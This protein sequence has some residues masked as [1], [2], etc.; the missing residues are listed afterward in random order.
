MRT[1]AQKPK[2]P[3]QA[4]PVKSTVPSRAH[5]RQSHEVNSILHLQRTIGNQAVQR[6]LQANAEEL[7]AGLTGT[8]PPRSWSDFS[9][10]PIY[11]PAAGAIQTKLAINKPG[12]LYEQEADRISEQ[13]MR[14]PEP[15]LQ[16]DCACGGDCHKCQ[17]EQP[18]H[19]REHLHT[20]RAGSGG[21][22]QTEVPPLVHEVLRSPGQPIDL[23]TRTFMEHRFGHDFGHVRVHT[24]EK[25]WDSTRAVN[26]LAYTAGHHLVFGACSVTIRN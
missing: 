24:D 18:R 3:Q 12:D 14:M 2:P 8:A 21:W 1:F 13:V 25:A 9:R 5:F 17:T 7:K 23:A 22:G 26:A 6:L 15:K 19:E 10:I 16:L 4:T 20:K 11:P